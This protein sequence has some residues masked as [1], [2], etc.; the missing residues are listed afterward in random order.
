MTNLD[1]EKPLFASERRP[2]LIDLFTPMNGKHRSH[3]FNEL[4][5]TEYSDG[6][7]VARVDAS[8][9]DGVS[10]GTAGYIAQTLPRR[11]GYQLDLV[12]WSSNCR[13]TV[14]AR[15]DPRHR[16]KNG[17]KTET[18][19]TYRKVA[20]Y[21][22]GTGGPLFPSAAAAGEAAKTWIAGAPKANQMSLP[23]VP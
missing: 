5:W 2:E 4:Q 7:R 8:F 15:E 3:R 12:V 14:A 19:W 17:S 23:S 1:R 20:I 11:S 13:V 16:L 18:V 22:V 10:L 21:H 9:I 6:V